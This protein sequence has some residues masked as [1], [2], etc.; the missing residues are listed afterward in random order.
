MMGGFFLAELC[1]VGWNEGNNRDSEACRYLLPRFCLYFVFPW[2]P[3]K[4]FSMNCFR[5]RSAM[6]KKSRKEKTEK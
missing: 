3:T 5:K 6:E 4:L 2:V 1:L